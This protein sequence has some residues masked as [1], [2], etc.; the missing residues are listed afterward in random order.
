[1]AVKFYLDKRTDRKGDAPIRVS[2]IIKGA[3]YL[4][5]TGYKV[6]PSKWDA[7]KQQ[8]RK[9]TANAAGITGQE[10][11][12]ALARI[13]AHFA[14][15][16]KAAL[17]DNVPVD[18][19]RLKAEFA[20]EFGRQ[21]TGATKPATQHAPQFWEYYKAFIAERSVTNQWTRA[22]FQKFNALKHHLSG[23]REQ[24]TFDDFTDVGFASFIAYLR[25]IKQLKN[26]TIGKQIGFLKWFLRWAALK[27]YNT[28]TAFQT[29]TPKLKAA[30]KQVVFL[31]WNELMKVFTYEIPATGT[32]VKLH[33]ATG[34]EYTK[35]VQASEGMAIARDIFCFCCFTSLR[36]S[37]ANNLRRSNITGE[38]LTITTVKTADTITIE[39]NKYARAVLQRYAD[40]DLGVFALPRITNQ[41]MNIYLK[42]LCE[43][44]EINKPITHTYYR[45]AQ[46]YDETLPKYELIG[47]HTGRRTFICNA[48]MLG[49]PA[50]IVMKWTG[51]ADYKSMKPYVDVTNAAKAQAMARFDQL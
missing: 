27:G 18:I 42:D 26:T 47:T 1:M 44:C 17:L 16:D 36:Y 22:T 31:D 9:G 51:H 37:D 20:R 45:G 5:S 14:A 33:T 12:A 10:I 29:F 24:P 21:H 49:I 19:E 25:D 43:L 23:W 2:I 8:A 15:I 30:P 38:S 11:N 6:N 34:R 48:L 28:N 39:L 46:R 32:K 4:T 40:A 41:R 7:D 35:T 50:E 13:T 3:R